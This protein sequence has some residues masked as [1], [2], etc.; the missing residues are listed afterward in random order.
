[1]KRATL[2]IIA[3]ITAA[4]LSACAPK[5][6]AP[7]PATSE[8]PAAANAAN[9]TRTVHDALIIPGSNALFAA[10]AE[11]PETD[12]AWTALRAAA[13]QTIEGAEALKTENHAKGRQAWIDAADLVIAATQLT[14]EA[15]AANNADELVFTNGDMMTGCTA[16]HQQFRGPDGKEIEAVLPTS[17]RQ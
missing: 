14:A 2:T 8:T 4:A 5:D 3:T 15:L 17:L 16:C 10:E 6:E 11:A 7:A 1:M 13:A 9:P 12:E